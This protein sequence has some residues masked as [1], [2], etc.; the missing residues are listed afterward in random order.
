MTPKFAQNGQEPRDA[1]KETM[2]CMAATAVAIL[3]GVIIA[4]AIPKPHGGLG[5]GVF[6]RPGAKIG[7]G[8]Q[9]IKALPYSES[10]STRWLLPLIK[11][12][13]D[14]ETIYNLPASNYMGAVLC[15]VDNLYPGQSR[16]VVRVCDLNGDNERSIVWAPGISTTATD[17]GSPMHSLHWLPDGKRVSVV[18]N[19]MLYII[20]VGP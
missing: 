13:D 20:P 8:M 17:Q 15:E 4:V 6:L 3:I 11:T 10:E 1:K 18:Y 2:G 9:A 5:N 12:S 19:D 16:C 7:H 14:R